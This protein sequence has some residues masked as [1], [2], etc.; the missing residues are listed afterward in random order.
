MKRNWINKKTENLNGLL[1]FS[2]GLELRESLLGDHLL[3]CDSGKRKISVE[4]VNVYAQKQVKFVR[5]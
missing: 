2:Y 1:I 5:A 4:D 3:V